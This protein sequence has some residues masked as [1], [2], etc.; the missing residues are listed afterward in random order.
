MLNSQFFHHKK[1]M[2][3]NSQM[4]VY[5]HFHLSFF[6]SRLQTDEVSIQE[7]VPLSFL[8]CSATLCTDPYTNTPPGSPCGCV[9]PIQVRLRFSVP[10]Y[11]FFPL[12]SE[13]AA[14]IAA[15]VYVK[16]SQVR[17]I[18][19]NAAYQQPDKT[20]AL[21][22]LVPLGEKFDNTTAFLTYQRFW[23][24]KVSINAYYFGNY[25]VL[26]VRY[27][28]L[29]RSPPPGVSG[30][31]NEPHL[32]NTNNARTVKPVGVDVH[33]RQPKDRISDGMIAIITLSTTVAVGSCL[34]TAWILIFTHNDAKPNPHVSL[35]ALNKPS[36]NMDCQLMQPPTVV[37]SSCSVFKFIQSCRCWWISYGNHA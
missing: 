8:D 24:K 23:H 28:G 4:K 11:T 26:Y 10:L 22:D 7:H 33:N 6:S 9:W 12:V 36:G 16:R 29:P 27:P 13:L 18:E 17:V 30:L 34:V 32:T 3:L 37:L 20:V 31:D 35:S 2:M 5:V 15:G 21:I 25:E 1:L 19:A 14:E